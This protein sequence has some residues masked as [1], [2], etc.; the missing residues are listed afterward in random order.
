MTT[1]DGNDIHETVT[2]E[3]SSVAAALVS[4]R[5][6][7]INSFETLQMLDKVT[8][9]MEFAADEMEKNNALRG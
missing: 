5:E 6:A 9:A 3:F 7:L 8:R 2:E 4:H 1:N